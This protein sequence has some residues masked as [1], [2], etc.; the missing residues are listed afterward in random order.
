MIWML[1]YACQGEKIVETGLDEEVQEEERYPYDIAESCHPELEGWSDPWMG[2][3][4]AA[5]NDINRMR[6]QGADCNTMGMFEPALPLEM[7]P[8]LHCAARYH[9][10]WMVENDVL[11]HESPGGAL[12]EGPQQRM[13]NAGFSGA[14]VGENVAAGSASPTDTVA[15][16]MGSDGH[17]ANIMSPVASVVGIG[18]YNTDQG[19]S[20]YWTLN[21][22]RID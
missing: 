5:L 20:H 1:A 18:Y 9:S 19:Y 10:L 4:F 14:P 2:A 3:E 6:E 17:C 7:E 13:E 21:T 8:Y 22:G 15:S 12:G 16:W 11:Q